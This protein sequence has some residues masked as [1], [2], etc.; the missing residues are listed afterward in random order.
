M[1]KTFYNCVHKPA[2]VQVLTLRQRAF[3]TGKRERNIQP[4]E[5]AE[6]EEDDLMEENDLIDILMKTSKPMK[7]SGSTGGDYI[8][9]KNN[10][11]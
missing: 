10:D 6:K 11:N 2:V 4:H 8:P 1:I 5:V 7:W 9:T 3:S